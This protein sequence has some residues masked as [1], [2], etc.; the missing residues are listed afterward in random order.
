MGDLPGRPTT[1]DVESAGRYAATS[2]LVG[3]DG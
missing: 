1:N 3:F 2:A